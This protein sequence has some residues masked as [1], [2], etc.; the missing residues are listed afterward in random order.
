[1]KGKRVWIPSRT[2]KISAASCTN[3]M[4]TALTQVCGLSPEQARMFSMHGLRV[5]GINYYDRRGVSVSLRAQMADHASLHSSQRYLRLQ[6]HERIQKLN[7]FV[8]LN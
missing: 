3:L 1:M 2:N 6:P 4:R 8:P 5:A 7:E